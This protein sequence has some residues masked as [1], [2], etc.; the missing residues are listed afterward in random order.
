MVIK[1]PISN[2]GDVGWIPGRATKL[3]HDYWA[4]FLYSPL[5]TTIQPQA[6]AKSM[7]SQ[8]KK[9]IFK[10]EWGFRLLQE[11]DKDA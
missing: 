5:T 8:K 10:K 4:H 7:G 2:A 9:K 3:T 1:N 11:E 6:T